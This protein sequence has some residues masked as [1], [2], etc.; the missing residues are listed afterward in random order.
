VKRL[1]DIRRAG[2]ALLRDRRALA[3]TEFA[4]AMPFF[5]TAG[6]GGIEVASYSLQVMRVN[7]IASQIADNASRIGDY[8]TLDNRK[9]YE[10]DI[11][12]LLTGA[13]L[14]AGTQMSLFTKGRVIISSLEYQTSGSNTQYIH[15]QRCMGTKRVASSYG[16]QG[17]TFA[18]GMGPS[19]REVYASKGEAVMF[20]E[21]KY[22]YQP[23][24]GSS[25]IGTPT[26]S[27]IA[28]FTVRSSRDL[29]QV[30]QRTPADPVMTC[31]KYTGTLS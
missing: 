7:Q 8:S 1:A 20:V 15:W 31:D 16:V 28:S 29:S 2:Q 17:T 12:D 14:A 9:I 19:G 30:Y 27:S 4:L 23:L 26:I 6:L 11:N 22:D 24:V 5:L 13:D 10:G 3:M 25:V 18:I 21:V